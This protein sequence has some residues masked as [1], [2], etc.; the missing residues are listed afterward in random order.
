M[1]IHL[2]LYSNGRQRSK[3]CYCLKETR[4]KN[5]KIFY[6]QSF[7]YLLDYRDPLR[8]DIQFCLMVIHLLG[9]AH[10]YKISYQVE[11]RPICVHLT[12]APLSSKRSI[13]FSPDS[14]YQRLNQRKKPYLLLVRKQPNKYLPLGKMINNPK[15][16]GEQNNTHL[17]LCTAWR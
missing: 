14:K 13:H 15:R 11:Y 16:A 2:G 17:G 6:H 7:K 3:V 12:C 10:V 1:T 9:S 8:S 4:S 5:S